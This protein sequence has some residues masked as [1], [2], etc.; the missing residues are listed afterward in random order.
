MISRIND[1]EYSYSKEN[2]FEVKFD[3]LKRPVPESFYKYYALSENSV[4][5][6]T[7][8]YV[9]ATHPN[10]LNDP[11]DCCKD[12]IKVDDEE[13]LSRLLGDRYDSLYNTLSE[14]E[15]VDFVPKALNTLMYRKYGIFSMTCNPY[16]ELMWS[17][18]SQKSGFCVELDVKKFMFKHYGP[19][20]VNYIDN[21]P[22]VCTSEVGLKLAVNI[23]CNVKR[24]AWSY[25]NE[26]RLIIPN[27]K[28]IDMKSFGDKPFCYNFGFEHNRQFKYPIEAIKRIILR[29][30]FIN[31]DDIVGQYESCIIVKMNEGDTNKK[32]LMD[33]KIKLL[34]FIIDNE[35]STSILFPNGLTGYDS[36]EVSIQKES[37]CMY[38]ITEI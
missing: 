28:G 19:F 2:L 6:I 24:S 22:Q 10:Q 30:D 18:Y 15:F 5:A 1:F 26:W 33:L 32:N 11:F 16:N 12:I 21:L 7:A 34:D 31:Q 29:K 37:Y 3:A 20:P 14:R 35:I 25:E 13:T 23:Q 8:P 17:H 4:D 38:R 36:Y 9:Y 27:P